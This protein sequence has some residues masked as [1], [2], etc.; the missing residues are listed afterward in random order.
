LLRNNI[1]DTILLSGWLFADLL[2]GLMVIFMVS[3]PGAPPRVV[4]LLVTPGQL[5]K[6]HCTGVYRAMQC[7]VQL[8]ETGISQGSVDWTASSDIN[9][10]VT[11]TPSHGT[12]KPGQTV[13]VSIGAIP[14]Q[15][16]AFIFRSSGNANAV[17]TQWSCTQLPQR[18]EHNFCRLV[19]NDPDPGRFSSDTQFAFQVLAPQINSSKFAYLKG[20]QV[21]IAIAYGGVD[22][23]NS[24]DDRDQGIAIAQNAYHALQAMGRQGPLFQKASYYSN[25]FTGNYDSSKVVID[26]YLVIR[27]DNANDT[28][29]SSNNPV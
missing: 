19:L 15:D 7:Q 25:L 12:L 26:V 3:I 13:N 14:C 4:E 27:P 6:T 23:I 17:L 21:G 2:L 11:F 28:C 18:L 10:S 8:T 24:G 20:R 1:R 22:D 9:N 5:D 16:G 29:N